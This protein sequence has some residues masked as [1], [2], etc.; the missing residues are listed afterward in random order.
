[1]LYRIEVSSRPDRQDN[2]GIRLLK[3]ILDLGIEGAS[4]VDVS[5]LYFIQGDLDSTQ[6]ERLS[7]ELLFDPIIQTC[8]WETIESPERQEEQPSVQTSQR[9]E[10]EV[11]YRPGVTDST[12]TSLLGGATVIGIEGISRAKTGNRFVLQ[13][14]LSY[15]N[16][17]RITESLLCNSLIQYY[18]FQPISPRFEDVP[19]SDTSLVELIDMSEAS[20]AELQELSQERILSL[21]LEEMRRVRDYFCQEGR[22]ATD[23]E[24]ECLAQT[25]SE[26]SG[27]KTFRGSI[28]YTETCDGETRNERIDSLLNTYIRAVTDTLD[29]PWVLSSFRDNAGIVDFDQEF[30]ISFKVETHNH[31]SA[32]EPFGGANTGV[33]GVVRDIIGVSAKPIANTDVL[34]FGPSDTD[35]SDLPQSVLHPK[36]IFSGVVAGIEDYGNKMGIPTVNGAILFD[37]G[38][39]ANPLVYCGCVGI[40]PKGRHRTEPEAGDKVLLV[41]GRTG[42]DGLRG[43]TFSSVELTDETGTKS[44]TA[45]QIGNPIEEKKFLEGILEARDEGLYNAVTDCGG[46]GL[47]SAVGEMGSELGVEVWLD[48]VPLKYSGLKPWEIWLSEAQE[49]MILSVPDESLE[50]AQEVFAHLDVEATVIGQFTGDG[51]LRL[52]HGQEKVADLSMEFLHRGIPRRNL[53]ALWESK[54]H[55]EPDDS[56]PQDLTPVLLRILSSPNVASKESVIRRYDHEVQGATFLKP[57]VGEVCDGPSDAAVIKPLEVTS[58]QGIAIGCGINPMYGLIDPYCMALSAVD[59]AIRNV[60]AI[61]GD[62]ERIAILDNFCWG[63]PDLPDRLGDLV[64]ACKGCYA[65]ALELGTPFISGKDSLYNEYWDSTV[66]R[67]VSIPPTLLISAM[68]IVPD[69]RRAVTMDLKEPGNLIYLLGATSPEMGGS[70]YYRDKGAIGSRAPQGLSDVSL[71]KRLHQAINRG[72]VR[73]CHDCS[74]GG[75][76]V[77]AAEMAFAGSV[78]LDLDLR[79]VIV[80]EPIETSD[81]V[82]FSESNGRFLLEVAPDHREALEEIMGDCA[83][84]MIG[85]TVESTDLRITGLDGKVAVSASHQE[86]RRAWKSGLNA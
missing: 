74:E 23:V 51:R 44:G 70:H 28:D 10:I 46:G 1:M 64:R 83:C 19:D 47:S 85:Q 54:H 33:G 50:R 21:N 41:G 62:P 71:L 86:L 40:A 58:W 15:D 45:V 56:P 4:E 39:I 6:V 25:W 29:K 3:D 60:V 48:R 30:E 24:M 49:R 26:H 7:S 78:G 61:G 22:P 5:D 34:C 69:V 9:W 80:S 17:V 53:V 52:M 55:P 66:N 77:S 68:A 16:A 72:L 32:L 31:P 12:A 18:S 59:E 38:Y 36:R 84:S 73:S 13:G 82:L 27:H 57:L 8:Q 81:L 11:S 35:F 67:K 20:D 79:A 75:I 65:A 14:R 2:R 76:A 63:N 43:A 42:R 37:P